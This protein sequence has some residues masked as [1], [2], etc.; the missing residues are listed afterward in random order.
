M[1]Y[2]TVIDV[3]I[4][5][6]WCL[7]AQ[8]QT[9]DQL[10]IAINELEQLEDADGSWR[11][12]VNQ[13]LKD[14]YTDLF[15]RIDLS[16]MLKAPSFD[17]VLSWRCEQETKL[18]FSLQQQE[19]HAFT[20]CMNEAQ[21]A[22]FIQF[23]Q[24][25]TEELMTTLPDNVDYLIKL[26][27]DRTVTQ[28]LRPKAEK[29]NHQQQKWLI[30]SD[31]DG[32]LLDHYSYSHSDADDTLNCLAKYTIPVIANTSKTF[33]EMLVLQAE[34][35]NKHPFIIENGAAVYIPNDY[36]PQRPT[37]MLQQGDF[38]VK[39][40]VQ[41]RPYWQAIIGQ[42]RTR[43]YD[44]FKTFAQLGPKQIAELTGLSAES[45]YR[46]S[47]RK[48]SEP[49]I[50]TADAAL[51]RKFIN[52]L[53]ELGANV[54]IGGRF[55]HVSG[56]SDKG[57]AMQWLCQQYQTAYQDTVIKSLAVGDGQNDAA[58]LEQADLAI[59]IRSPVHDL[60]VLS[61]TKGCYI[62][63]YE[64]PKGWSQSVEKFMRNYIKVGHNN[65]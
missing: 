65:G 61:R 63:D 42:L 21:L 20:D 8:A 29:V 46:S 14:C 3:V 47:Q 40:F 34:L 31:M 19:Q 24:R 2:N 26:D 51:K 18:R 57:A 12:Y 37:G 28:L 36:F 52:E 16:I 56:H 15:S 11:H 59:L 39:S 49:I 9:Q 32:T 13:Q 7:G 27:N 22:R 45:S 50:W 53:R 43:Y 35:N 5:E 10:S 4:F 23:Y 1:G 41:K 58:M 44:C 60:P 55:I 25:I 33:A 62:S 6:G 54:L 48:Y 30:F 64:G 38:W 17:C